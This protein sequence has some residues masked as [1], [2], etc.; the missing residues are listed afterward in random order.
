MSK[1]MVFNYR[2]YEKLLEENRKLR[3][4]IANLQIRCRIAEAG[5][6]EWIPVT[7]RLPEV[8]PDRDGWA[9]DMSNR[10]LICCKN[11]C[12]DVAAY[13][14]DG[15]DRQYW[16]DEDGLQYEDVRAWMPLPEPYKGGDRE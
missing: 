13:E 12:M 8:F 11:G 16:V 2:E 1:P 3:D 6:P 7:E 10:V 4:D 9:F 14:V 5:R 15:P